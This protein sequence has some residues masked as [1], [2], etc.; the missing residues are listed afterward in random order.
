MFAEAQKN[1]NLRQPASVF[2][3]PEEPSHPIFVYV[4]RFDRYYPNEHNYAKVFCKA[5]QYINEY[6]RSKPDFKLTKYNI[7]NITGTAMLVAYRIFYPKDCP[8]KRFIKITGIHPDILY[9]F[10]EELIT[11]T[12]AAQDL[13]QENPPPQAAPARTQP[14]PSFFNASFGG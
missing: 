9:N 3:S 5:A 13:I 6:Q 4:T 11:H 1:G 7:H 12:S 8:L 14:D 2:E 10:A